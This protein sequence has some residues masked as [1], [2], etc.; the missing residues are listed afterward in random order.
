MFHFILDANTKTLTVDL[1]DTR[2][3]ENLNVS[4]LIDAKTSDKPLS[5]QEKPPKLSSL[6][7]L[8]LKAVENVLVESAESLDSFVCQFSRLNSDLDIVANLLYETYHEGTP[9]DFVT[10]P[11]GVGDVI[12]ALF[13]EDETWYRAFVSS[14]QPDGSVCVTFMDYGNLESIPKSDIA[15]RVRYL[16]K[17]LLRYPPMRGVTCSLSR[18]S[19][20]GQRFSWT[21]RAHKAFVHYVVEKEFRAR[22][23][24]DSEPYQ[25]ILEEDSGSIHA[26]LKRERLVSS[27]EN[28]PEV[29]LDDFYELEMDVGTS[30]DVYVT[31]V[32]TPEKFFVQQAANSEAIDKGWLTFP[33]FAWVYLC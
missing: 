25:T 23:S 9:P 8:Q 30:C 22:L 2:G 1:Y 7:K 28:E 13:S 21:P 6:P 24:S 29:V 20:D 19:T 17:E 12:A 33:F 18:V 27:G 11:V 10:A 14:L 32:V 3:S 26:W 4:D 16:A 31:S 5:S 15:R